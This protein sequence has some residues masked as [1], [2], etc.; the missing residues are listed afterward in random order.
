MC[1]IKKIYLKILEHIMWK[2]IFKNVAH[3]GPM[4]GIVTEEKKNI[5]YNNLSR[6]FERIDG[7]LRFRNKKYSTFMKRCKEKE[8]VEN[9]GRLCPEVTRYRR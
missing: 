1:N 6:V 3:A 8:I 7:G 5:I 9:R 4:K 2:E